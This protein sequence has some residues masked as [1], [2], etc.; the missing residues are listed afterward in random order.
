VTGDPFKTLRGRFPGWQCW[1]GISGLLYARKVK[2]SPPLIVRAYSPA[3]L[4]ELIKLA[5][6]PTNGV[7]EKSAPGPALVSIPVQ[8]RAPHELRDGGH[9]YW[10]DRP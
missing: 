3:E 2:A 8:R 4:A 6:E 10:Y 1:R 5:E 9:S 7:S